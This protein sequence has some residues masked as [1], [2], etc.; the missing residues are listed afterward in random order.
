MSEEK[1]HKEHFDTIAGSENYRPGHWCLYCTA[2]IKLI[3]DNCQALAQIP[4]PQNPILILNPKQFQIKRFRRDWGGQ[5]YATPPHP[6]SLGCHLKTQ[7]PQNCYRDIQAPSSDQSSKLI[8]NKTLR[9]KYWKTS[10]DKGWRE[11]DSS[12]HDYSL[13]K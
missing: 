11:K 8:C 6:I 9:N 7:S 2:D 5:Y 12:F 1:S 10:H 4:V 3:L 13:N